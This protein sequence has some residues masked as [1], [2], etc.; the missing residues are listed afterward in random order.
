MAKWTASHIPDQNSRT[1]VVT[2]TGGLGFEDALALAR[3]GADVIIAGRSPSKGTAAVNEIRRRV[4]CA[5]V[6]FGLLDLANLDSIKA[7]G[8]GL[9]NSLDS[10]DLLINNAG[11]MTPP[12]RH[13][14]TDGF[15]LQFGTNHLGHFA[16]AGQLLPLL[17]KGDR[18]RVVT[19]SSIAARHG[20][21]HFDD[22]QFERGYKPMVAYSQSKL[23]CLMFA[24]ELQRRCNAAGWSI[25]S[26]A[27][28]PGVS[29]TD[30]IPNGSGE[31]SAAGVLRRFMWFLFQPPARGALPTLYAATSL[32]AR[33]GAYYGPNKL[34]E[35]RGYPATAKAPPQ[36]L[37]IESA[38][39]LW[40]ESER[41]TG[42]AY[43]SQ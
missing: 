31:W 35:V 2:G 40:T 20:A 38:K 23:A 21:I 25:E 24:F 19:V 43:P 7:F 9:R 3:G 18:A 34:S 30:L 14:T 37:D 6:R 5:N 28:H 27:A 36:S 13:V 17:R 26:I 39:R 29:R 8:E 4:P 32:K 12:T 10:L 42:M 11:V 15:E 41:L 1:A 33:G 16:L 22:L